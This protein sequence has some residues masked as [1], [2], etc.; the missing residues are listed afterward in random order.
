MKRD[1]TIVRL[2]SEIDRLNSLNANSG[3]EAGEL[4]KKLTETQRKLQEAEE[5]ISRL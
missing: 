3:L 2:N 5:L 4:S 1:E